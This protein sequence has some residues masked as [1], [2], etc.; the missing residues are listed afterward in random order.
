MAF[1][2]TV[3]EFILGFYLVGEIDDPWTLDSYFGLEYELT[4]FDWT[5]QEI[6]SV[7]LSSS[8]L[9][10]FLFCATFNIG[11][12]LWDVLIYVM[13]KRKQIKMDNAVQCPTRKITVLG[14]Q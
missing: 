9:L 7:P 12:I 11:L 5:Q 3:G 13:G 8:H 14:N 1:S 6:S 10:L 4:M 2:L